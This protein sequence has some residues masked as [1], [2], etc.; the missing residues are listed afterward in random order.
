MFIRRK[1]RKNRGVDMKKKAAFIGIRL[2]TDEVE[3]LDRLVQGQLNRS[4]V[5]RILIAEFL[6]KPEKEQKEILFKQMFGT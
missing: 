3:K 6:G 2:P 4:Q 5:I 1:R